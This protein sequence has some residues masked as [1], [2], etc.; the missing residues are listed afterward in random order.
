MFG[1]RDV[2]LHSMNQISK[3]NN[4]KWPTMKAVNLFVASYFIKL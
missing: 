3:L 4:K 1:D 2:I